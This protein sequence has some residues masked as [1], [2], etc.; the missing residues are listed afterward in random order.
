MTYARR[1]MRLPY[2]ITLITGDLMKRKSES[3]LPIRCFPIQ[4]PVSPMTY[5]GAYLS[6]DVLTRLP[7]QM[8]TL[9]QKR[10]NRGPRRGANPSE[11]SAHE[12]IFRSE[13]H[14]QPSSPS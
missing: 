7:G 11:V 4:L 2:A 10:Q 6:Q 8:V 12:S 14:R 3:T 1:V 9:R 5:I 13:R